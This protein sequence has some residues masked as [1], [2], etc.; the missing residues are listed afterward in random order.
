M[1]PV[2]K[3][4]TRDKD[5]RGTG[6]GAGKNVV[7][8][9]S[10]LQFTTPQY[11][12][13][14]MAD[15]CD[16]QLVNPFVLCSPAHQN[17]HSSIMI[18]SPSTCSHAFQHIT[19]LSSTPPPDLTLTSPPPPFPSPFISSVFFYFL[20]LTLLLRL[21]LFIPLFLFLSSLSTVPINVN[22]R[23]T[24]RLDARIAAAQRLRAKY[25]GILSHLTS[26]GALLT[27]INAVD[28]LRCSPISSILMSLIPL[29]EPSYGSFSPLPTIIAVFSPS[30]CFMVFAQC[31]L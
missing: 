23:P 16:L 11:N 8:Y 1:P 17:F 20:D 5:S 2:R 13:S 7:Q 3:G 15:R 22:A 27:H 14:F 28:L 30:L 26:S 6:A 31:P 12:S 18:L 21:F 19:L 24:R 9:S 25:S 29:I 10:T 4:D